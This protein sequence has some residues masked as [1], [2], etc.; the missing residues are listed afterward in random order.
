[1]NERCNCGHCKLCYRCK[2]V[3]VGTYGAC[4]KWVCN[5]CLTKEEWKGDC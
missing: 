1:M 4:G 2:K 3:R 5:L